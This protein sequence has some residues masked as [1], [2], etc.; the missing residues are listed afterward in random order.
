MLGRIQDFP[1]GG[2]GVK[3][4][5]TSVKSAGPEPA[6]LDKDPGSARIL[7]AFSCYLSLKA[8]WYK[9]SKTSKR[10]GGR[11]ILC[12]EREVRGSRARLLR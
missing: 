6:C 2:G 5:V 3:S 4:Y 9:T 12:H 1:G 11:K 7:D 10:G 8:F